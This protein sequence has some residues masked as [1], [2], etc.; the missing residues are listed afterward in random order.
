MA[1]A[2]AWLIVHG[3]TFGGSRYHAPWMPF[4]A[5]FASERLSRSPGAAALRGA[6]RWVWA[7]I[8]VACLVLWAIEGSIYF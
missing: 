5:A 4:L 2:A 7:G 1:L 3:V 8:A 6:R